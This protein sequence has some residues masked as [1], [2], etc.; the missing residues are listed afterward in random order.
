MY[1]AFAIPDVLHSDGAYDHSHAAFNTGGLRIRGLD[2][3]SFTF[4]YVH[5]LHVPVYTFESSWHI[6]PFNYTICLIYISIVAR[7]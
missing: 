1:A 3:P 6:L 5:V 4:R 7:A 2:T